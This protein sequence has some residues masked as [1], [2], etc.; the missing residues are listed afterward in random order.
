[1]KVS[2]IITTY[3]W[4]EALELCLMSVFGQRILPDEVLVADDGSGRKTKE[5]ISRYRKISKM[6]LVH[7]WQEDQGF[8]AAAIR[9]K[10]VLQSQFEY[11]IFLDGDMI[12]H[13][14][15]VRDHLNFAEKGCFLQGSRV[16]IKNRLSSELL[17]KKMAKVTP[18]VT[19]LSNRKNMLK[20]PLLT[21]VFSFKNRRLKGI[22]TCN[23]SLFREDFIKINGFN[24]DFCGWGRE[25]SELVVRLFNSGLFR[26]NLRFSAIQ[27]HLWHRKDSR[28][29]LDKNEELLR[30][31][32]QKGI[33]RCR[34]GLTVDIK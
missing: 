25:D 8:R 19:G 14:E 18:F 29:R 15:F 11:L 31:A 17:A 34:S 12:L 1:M 20:I 6:P 9:N 23:F 22:R 27:Y 24:E 3:N 7:I 30:L 33:K 26:K 10:A 21:K 4:P 5:V 16:M 28:A 13:P 32:I 2:L